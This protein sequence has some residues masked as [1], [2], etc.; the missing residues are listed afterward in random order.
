MSVGLGNIWLER[1][2]GYESL[3]IEMARDAHAAAP[4]LAVT[5]VGI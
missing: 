3:G 5:K 4:H 1:E 2:G